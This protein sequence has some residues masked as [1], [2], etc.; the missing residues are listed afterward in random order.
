MKVTWKKL[1]IKIAAWLFAEILLNFLG[2]DTLADY[3]EFVFDKHLVSSNQSNLIIKDLAMTTPIDQNANLNPKH[4]PK[5]NV[6]QFS[7][8]LQSIEGNVE[9]LIQHSPD[10]SKIINL[11]NI[12]K[13]AA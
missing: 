4:S 9:D 8:K 10:S 3:G 12:N 7:K 5:H 11:P 13:R 6:V 2:L 1:I